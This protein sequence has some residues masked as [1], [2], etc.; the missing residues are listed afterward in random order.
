M[1]TIYDGGESLLKDEE[2]CEVIE[3]PEP[4]NDFQ[5]WVIE[6]IQILEKRISELEYP[7]HK[8]F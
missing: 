1:A 5:A 7:T 4:E 3:Y 2:K 8:R 6:A